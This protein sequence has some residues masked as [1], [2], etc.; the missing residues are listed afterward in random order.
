MSQPPPQGYAQPPPQGY[1][2]PPPQGYAPPPQVQTQTV[3]V[4]H[5]P[6]DKST[7]L[8][9]SLGAAWLLGIHVSS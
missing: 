6:Y 2:Q 5:P 7:A 9:A 3:I 4:Q 8:F 1:A